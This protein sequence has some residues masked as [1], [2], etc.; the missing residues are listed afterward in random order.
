MAIKGLTTT[1]PRPAV[2]AKLRKG[3]PKGSNRPGQDL[4]YFRLDPIDPADDVL[5]G[6]LQTEY[7]A[8]PNHIEIYL[9]YATAEQNFTAWMEEW[10][11]SELVHRC[12]GETVY[13]YDH[14][15]ALVS[16]GEAC[17]YADDQAPRTRQRPGCAPVGRLEIFIPALVQ[18]AGRFGLVTAETHSK[19]D[20]V[21]LS[22]SLAFYE[23]NF[24]DLRGKPFILSRHPRE[25]STPNGKG[26]RARRTKWLM[27]LQPA[28]EWVMQQLTAPSVASGARLSDAAHDVRRLPAPR[29]S[30]G[31]DDESFADEVEAVARDHDPQEIAADVGAYVSAADLAEIDEATSSLGA[32]FRK[33]A[34]SD[35]ARDAGSAAGDGPRTR[36][37]CEDCGI[38]IAA[39]ERGGVTYASQQVAALTKQKY[40]RALCSTCADRARAGGDLAERDATRPAKPGRATRKMSTF[41]HSKIEQIY[42][43]LHPDDDDATRSAAVASLFETEFAHGPRDA[44]YDEARIIMADLLRQQHDFQKSVAT[45]DAA[46][47]QREAREG[48]I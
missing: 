31:F 38:P 36:S 10:S 32:R 30:G 46:R 12:D 39:A 47:L 14:R 43:T 35:V 37:T 21:A 28:S 1:T 13:A 18:H 23:Q 42:H 2:I 3:A 45:D 33:T 4:E 11:A 40:G 26:G 20:L 24:G 41:Q 22:S 7:G 44:T 5:I 15:G 8:A 25:I 9:P 6:A 48:A 27:S 16:T 19:H 17:P 34:P 29:G